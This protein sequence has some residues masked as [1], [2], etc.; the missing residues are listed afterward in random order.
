M[1][2]SICSHLNNAEEEE[3]MCLLR[4]F[5]ERMEDWRFTVFPSGYFVA[6]SRE[7]RLVYCVQYLP[8]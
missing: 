7:L 1:Q 4:F 3:D 8:W 2:V 6:W 5:L